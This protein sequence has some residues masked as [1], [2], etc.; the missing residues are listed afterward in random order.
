MAELPYSCR[1]PFSLDFLLRAQPVFELPA[2]LTSAGEVQFMRT[3]S[4]SFFHRPRMVAIFMLCHRTTVCSYA[5]CAAMM[6]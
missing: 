5:A 4:D 1:F 6:R 2:R 3:P